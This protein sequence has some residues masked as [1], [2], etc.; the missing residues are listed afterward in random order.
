[1]K[2]NPTASSRLTYL[3][4][5]KRECRAPSERVKAMERMKNLDRSAEELSGV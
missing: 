5:R 2:M 1:M 4:G 3:K